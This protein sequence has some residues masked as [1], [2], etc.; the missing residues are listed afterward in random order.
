M[1]LRPADAVPVTGA[2]QPGAGGAYRPSLEEAE[3]AQRLSVLGAQLVRLGSRLG[4]RPGLWLRGVRGHGRELGAPPVAGAGDG[5][6]FAHALPGPAL[7]GPAHP[8]CARALTRAT[9]L[10]LSCIVPEFLK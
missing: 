10:Q 7:P 3:P 9:F 6:S 1:L 8:V 2:A 4:S 5:V